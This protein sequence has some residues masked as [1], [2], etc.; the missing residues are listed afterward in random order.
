MGR[1]DSK[2]LSRRSV[3]LKRIICKEIKH[4]P[5]HY[6]GHPSIYSGPGEAQ[7]A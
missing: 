5:L 7:Q 2:D 4:R 6:K 3:E 1:V